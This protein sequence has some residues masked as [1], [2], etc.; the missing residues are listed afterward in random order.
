MQASG[1]SRTP[2]LRFKVILFVNTCAHRPR[3]GLCAS[4]L[5][6][7][8]VQPSGGFQGARSNRSEAPIGFRR[9]L[10]AP[11]SR[12]RPWSLPAPLVPPPLRP[13]GPGHL[14]HSPLSSPSPGRSG[15]QVP[16]PPSKLSGTFQAKMNSTALHRRFPPPSRRQTGS[17]LRAGGGLAAVVFVSAALRRG[18]GQ[19]R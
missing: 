8:V 13:S 10:K 17:P 4:G 19:R 2:P 16:R 11:L 18:P 7:P 3:Y 15:R 14:Q 6:F 5:S 9:K 12:E 1:V